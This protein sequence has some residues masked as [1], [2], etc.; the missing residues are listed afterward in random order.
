MFAISV[1]SRCRAA[2]PDGRVV[3]NLASPSVI[4]QSERA[5]ISMSWGVVTSATDSSVSGRLLRGAWRCGVGEG[6]GAI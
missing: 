5:T 3:L 4:S 2:M 1:H 6:V